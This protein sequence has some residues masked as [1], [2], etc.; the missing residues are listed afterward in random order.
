MK[1]FNFKVSA[2]MIVACITLMMT[3][4]GSQYQNRLVSEWNKLFVW[5]KV[6]DS[7]WCKLYVE[8]DFQGSTNI[9]DSCINDH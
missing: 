6:N 1:S 2:M 3:G 7:D 5:N 8:P 4:F 9:S